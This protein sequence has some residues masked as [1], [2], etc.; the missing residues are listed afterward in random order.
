MQTTLTNGKIYTV[1]VNIDGN[2]YTLDGRYDQ[3]INAIRNLKKPSLY[4]TL[5]G[6]EEILAEYD[7]KN[8]MP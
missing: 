8:Q 1:A 7:H 2:N 4:C 3:K 6:S 5:T